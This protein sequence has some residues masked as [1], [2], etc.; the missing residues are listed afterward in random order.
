[1]TEARNLQEGCGLFPGIRLEPLQRA[2]REG[3]RRLNL[4]A[5]CCLYR[6]CR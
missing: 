2:G 3:D 4:V 5:G 1:M 6:W